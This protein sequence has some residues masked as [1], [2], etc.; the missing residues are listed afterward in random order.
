ML[1]LYQYGKKDLKRFPIWSG[2]M[3]YMFFLLLA[4]MQILRFYIIKP[5]KYNGRDIGVVDIIIK[6]MYSPYNSDFF[7]ITE[8]GKSFIGS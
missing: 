4:Y 1:C 8:F 5:C 3:I 2:E 6:S 7:L